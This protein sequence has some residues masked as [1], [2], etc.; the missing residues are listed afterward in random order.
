MTKQNETTRKVKIEDLEFIDKF[1]SDRHS[2]G[3]DKK[4]I[5]QA[6]GWNLITKYLKLDR[7]TYNK[8]VVVPIMEDKNV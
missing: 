3:I 8:L 4:R 6:R 2:K 5:S 7:E 1:I